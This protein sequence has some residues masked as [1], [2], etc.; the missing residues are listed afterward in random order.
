VAGPVDPAVRIDIWSDVICPWCYLGAGRLDAALDRLDADGALSRSA[1][2]IRWRA[3]ELDPRAP[4]EPT[5]LR[6]A[7]EK[8]YGPGSFDGMT[9]RLTAL[10]AP[11]GID[12]RF[13]R[14]Q[15]VNTFD[16]H[17]LI[18]WAA[19]QP[20]GQGGLVTDL[21]RAYF[22]EGADVS[23]HA[24]LA[25]LAASAGLDAD[26]A[27]E[28]LAGGGHADEVRADEA[29]AREIDITGVPAF[30]VDGRAMIPGAQEVDTI[31]KVLTRALERSA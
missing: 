29:A 3:F 6:S 10:G 8:K 9:A 12:Y 2:E 16:A 23:D 22:T 14:A 21:F 15:R 5:D 1:V 19:T 26:Q 20:A 31:V 28:V 11:E 7:L 13:D 18:S 4:A 24:T 30:L 25:G 27:R 17:R